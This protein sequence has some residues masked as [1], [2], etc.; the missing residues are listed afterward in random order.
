MLGILRH[1]TVADTANK[2]EL[3]IHEGSADVS[4]DAS[5][6]I[7]TMLL[8]RLHCKYG[9]MFFPSSLLTGSQVRSAYG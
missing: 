8:L 5:A 9:E 6:S 3:I 2:C 1:K 7:S 4:D